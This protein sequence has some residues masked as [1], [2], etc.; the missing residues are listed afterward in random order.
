MWDVVGVR[1][2]GRTDTKEE[3]VPA[4]NPNDASLSVE[5]HDETLQI[6]CPHAFMTE[7]PNI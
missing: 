6:W 1:R 3:Q 2:E 5:L 4:E 7:V